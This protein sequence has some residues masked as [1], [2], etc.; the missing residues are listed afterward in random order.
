MSHS[1]NERDPFAQLGLQPTLDINAIK[2]AYFSRLSNAPPQAR[3][4]VEFR[5]LRTAYEALSTRE[6]RLLAFLRAP[7]SAEE[8]QAFERAHGER[9]AAT[10]KVAA[11]AATT[12]ERL[13]RFIQI[14]SSSSLDEALERRSP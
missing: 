4:G 13:E 7:P 1:D 14:Y 8:R 11:A 9:L 3:G 5:A 2:R 10:R 6:T 12:K